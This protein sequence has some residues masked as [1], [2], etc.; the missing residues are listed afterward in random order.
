[1]IPVT[2]PDGSAW[3]LE[4]RPTADGVELVLSIPE[5][6]IA[7]TLQATRADARRFADAVRAAAGDGTMRTFPHPVAREG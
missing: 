5:M 6:A 2:P 1:M 7:V 4:S 3:S